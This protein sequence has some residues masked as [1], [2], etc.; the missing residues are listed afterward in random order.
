MSLILILAA[1]AAP[2]RPDKAPALPKD[3]WIG[4]APPAGQWTLIAFFDPDWTSSHRMMW[5]LRRQRNVAVVGVSKA[6]KGRLR[7]FAEELEISYPLLPDGGDLIQA[8]GVKVPSRVLVGPDGQ[9]LWHEY[10]IER[11]LAAPR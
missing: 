5:Q 11:R 8:F 9:V 4:E 1:C 7:S 3:G 6:G 2:S 10:D